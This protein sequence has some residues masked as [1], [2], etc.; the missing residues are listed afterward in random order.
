MT[1]VVEHRIGGWLPRD[2]RVVERWLAKKIVQCSVKTQAFHPVIQEF[3]NLI[4][5]DAEIYMGFHQ[6]FEQVPTKP[7][8]NNDPAGKP[9]VRD[10]M[11]MLTLFNK[12]LTE[13]PAFEESAYEVDLVGFPINAIL[14]WPMGTPAGFTT[15]INPKVNA[16]FKNAAMPDFVEKYVCDP[17]AE[18]HG[19]ESWDDF[20]TRQ[21]KPGVRPVAF[22]DDDA[23]V[24]STC[25][26]TV[27]CIAHDIKALDT[28][29]LKG[30][31]YSLNHMLNNDALA[32]HFLNATMYHRWHSP[33]NGKVVKTVMIPG[34]YYAESPAM[35]FPNPDPADNPS[36]GL[37][38][39]IAVG[40]AEV[41][42]CQI[43]IKEGDRIAK[44][45]KMGMFHFGGSTYCLIFGPQTKIMFSPDYPVNSDVQ[46]NAAI[47]TVE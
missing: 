29:W 6:M 3:K 16:Q 13:A 37:I 44:G 41:S 27:Y 11:T 26:S 34:T 38:C 42:T 5:Q 19:F 43:V 32:P 22:P 35:G 10:Y 28:F 36:I 14:D 9:Q 8:Y 30:E 17:S 39:F 15:F 18:Y 1:T 20:F 24:N 40:M 33:V 7:L 12:I 45:T 31:P 46:L 2:H 25:E 21:F 4:E 23:I 47:A